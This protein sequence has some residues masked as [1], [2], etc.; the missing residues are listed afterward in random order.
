MMKKLIYIAIGFGLPLISSCSS[1]EIDAWQAKGYVWFPQ[2]YVNF[3][4]KE[5]PEVNSGE[6][7]LVPIPFRVA[8]TVSDKDR[9]VEVDIVRQPEDSRTTYELQ[10]P[11]KFRANH[12]V[13]TMYVKVTNSDHLA[14]IHDTISFEVKP[15]ID[16]EPG[17]QDNVK[18]SLCLFNGFAKPSWWDANTDYYMGLFSQLKMEVYYIV[19]GSDETP[20]DEDGYGGNKFKFIK[21]Q[22][23]EYVTKNN[24]HYPADDENAPGQP[25]TFNSNKY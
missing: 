10:K 7:Y 2:E 3:T 15:S 14:T 18:T 20:L 6:T 24:L 8:S 21:Y 22:L 13:D 11:V 16:F 1:D 23:T 17:L 12:I 19:T 25:V 4:F 5:H 9:L